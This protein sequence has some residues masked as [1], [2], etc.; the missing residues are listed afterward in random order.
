MLQASA[1]DVTAHGKR[2]INDQTKPTMAIG[3]YKHK[4]KVNANGTVK[5]V[6]V[7]KVARGNIVDTDILAEEISAVCS[8]SEGDVLMVLRSMEHVLKNHLSKGDVVKLNSVGSFSPTLRGKC[9]DSAEKVNQFSI[10]STGVRFTPSARLL[11]GIR[12]AG[13]RLADKRI[14]LPAARVKKIKEE[15]NQ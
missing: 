13:V 12:N 2:Y 9:V 7:A 4:R 10:L 6:Y 14:L 8:A 11:E 15:E 5:E 1:K 3:Y